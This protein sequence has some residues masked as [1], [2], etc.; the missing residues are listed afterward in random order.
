MPFSIIHLVS[1]RPV[2]QFHL[3]EIR[4]VQE[5]NI[6]NCD[7]LLLVVLNIL[8]NLVRITLHPV[9]RNTGGICHAAKV[10]TVEVSTCM[11]RLVMTSPFGRRNLK[12]D[13]KFSCNHQH[14]MRHRRLC[15]HLEQLPAGKA[16]LGTHHF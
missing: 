16:R 11:V 7:T 12:T 13:R 5:T 4:L 3:L 8:D 10:T 14:S 15:A 1:S 6:V 2:A 9:T